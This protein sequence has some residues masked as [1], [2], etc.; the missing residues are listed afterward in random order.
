MRRHV[1]WAI[2]L[3]TYIIAVFHRSSLGVAGVTAADRFG[4]GTSLLAILSVA[5]LAVYAGMQIPVGVLLDRFGSR[6]MLVGGGLLMVAGQLL[7]A[8]AGDIGPAIAARVLIGVGDAMTFISVLRVVAMWYPPR[9]N[10]LMVQLTGMVGQLGAL[11]SAVPLVVLLRDAGWTATFLGA[12]VLG[13]AAV[14]LVALTLKDAP[15]QQQGKTDKAPKALK[16]SWEHPGTR[17]G[18]WTHFAAQFSGSVF[19]L[20]WGFPFLTQGEGLAPATAALLLSLLTVG[21]IVLGP[22]IG[23]FCGRLPYHRSTL[24]LGIVAG[25]AV[26]WAVVLLWPGRAPLAV[27]TG[28]VLVLAVNGPGSMIGFDYARSFNPAARL[29]GATGIVNVGGFAASIVVIVSIGVLLDLQTPAGAAH[30]SLGAY[31]WAFAVQYVL[32]GIGAAQVWRYR[33]TTRRSMAPEHLAAMRR[34]EALPAHG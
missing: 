13:A 30:P 1:M 19:A 28:L 23:H 25:S 16:R 9:R 27:L 3:T 18:L 21:G 32:W 26:A 4:V 6:R 11:S 31:K 22:V 17:L 5:Q 12:A 33:R 20:L 8:Y 15:A 24:V 34:G 2:G 29:G 14:A 10:P 7:F